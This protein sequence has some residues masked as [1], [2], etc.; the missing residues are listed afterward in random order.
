MKIPVITRDKQT[1]SVR[2]IGQGQ[3]VLLLH[4]LGMNSRH[5]LP[6]VLPY[7]RQF[8]FYMP[9]LRGA[10]HSA[11][12]A[13]NQHDIIHN[14]MED[15]QDIVQHFSLRNFLLVG[16]SMGATTALHWQREAG[17]SEVKHYLHIDQTPCV[18][19]QEDWSFGLFGQQQALFFYYLQQ[20]KDLLAQYSSYPDIQSLPFAIRKKALKIL[21]HTFT[22]VVG[23]KSVKPI[24]MAATYWPKLLPLV[25]PSTRLIDLQ[26]YLQSYLNSH[27]YRE[28]LRQCHVPVTVMVGMRS[29]LYNPL[30][31]IAIADY[32][33]YCKVIPFEKSGHVPLLDEP[34]KFGVELGRF[35][36]QGLHR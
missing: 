28:S 30:G 31:Q 10:G 5:W 32:A 15:V 22:E 4:G 35:L 25:F 11:H 1:L 7:S 20:L 9:D 2:V 18:P 6:F 26:A 3:P 23:R 36:R 17:F 34:I 13:F 8:K 27:D 29:P 12:I 16:Y 14:H 19:N 24:F 21:S 33:P